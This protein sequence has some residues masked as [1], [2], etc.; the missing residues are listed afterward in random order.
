LDV[1]GINACCRAM[2]RALSLSPSWLQRRRVYRERAN[3]LS[4]LARLLSVQARLRAWHL[5]GQPSG[6]LAGRRR[7]KQR[8]ALSFLA[9]L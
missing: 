9:A 4:T 6:T 1:A 7:G 5:A 8:A 2:L 3:N